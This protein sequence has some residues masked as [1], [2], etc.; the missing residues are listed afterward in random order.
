[1]LC[2]GAAFTVSVS[3][4]AKF[5]LSAGFYQDAVGNKIQDGVLFQLVNLGPNG[6]FD[7]INVADGDINGLQQWVSG[8]DS[9]INDP[10]GTPEYATL[11][12]FDSQDGNQVG[13]ATDGRINRS[14]IFIASTGTKF[15]IRWF[16]GLAAANFG[17]I[18][19][20]GGQTYGQFTRQDDPLV[21]GPLYDGAINGLDLWVY[22]ASNE[23]SIQLDKLRTVDNSGADALTTGRATNVVIP[24]PATTSLAVFGLAALGIRRRRR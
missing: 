16:P 3:H 1:V 22:P 4:A 19:L 21:S 15:G 24:E 11:A 2:V 17:S 7:P 23:A 5:D 9:V 8:D 12:A 20:S 6:V 14:F 18:T 13:P 10:F